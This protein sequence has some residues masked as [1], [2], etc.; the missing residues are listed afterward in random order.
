[1]LLLL[2]THRNIRPTQLHTLLLHPNKF[3]ASLFRP[4][5]DVFISIKSFSTTSFH[6]QLSPRRLAEKG[7]SLVV[8]SFFLSLQPQKVGIKHT[9]CTAHCLKYCQSVGYPKQSICKFSG[10]HLENL[11]PFFGATMP[12]NPTQPLS[13]LQLLIPYS[14][15]ADLSSIFAQ[16]PS[17][18]EKTFRS[19]T[20][21][22]KKD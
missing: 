14:G 22:R 18:V 20:R 8:S 12:Q 17:I 7:Q 10:K 3:K 15:L 4:P 13:S 6:R 2:I 21:Y 9:F 1:M 11:H 19:F 5:E 16:L